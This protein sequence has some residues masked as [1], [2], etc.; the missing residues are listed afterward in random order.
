MK[1]DVHFED[2]LQ[3]NVKHADLGHTACGMIAAV[4]P[5]YDVAI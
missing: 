3:M 1:P 5:G 2:Y 4:A